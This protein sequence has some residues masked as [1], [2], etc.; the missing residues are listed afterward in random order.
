[1]KHCGYNLD[2]RQWTVSKEHPYIMI[3]EFYIPQIRGAGCFICPCRILT[4][5]MINIQSEAINI[6]ALNISFNIHYVGKNF[7]QNLLNITGDTW[8]MR[9]IVCILRFLRGIKAGFFFLNR[10]WF[11]H[12]LNICRADQYESNNLK[13][14]TIPMNLSYDIVT[15]STS[16]IYAAPLSF[17]SPAKQ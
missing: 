12:S 5:H 11:F 10:T 2:S 17:P 13:L 7:G 8:C 9:H 3:P 14:S 6:I 16:V 1:M 15:Q 4:I